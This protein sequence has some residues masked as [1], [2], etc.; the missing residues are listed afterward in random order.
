MAGRKASS[1]LATDPCPAPAS[2]SDPQ[3]PFSSLTPILC[4]P[5]AGQL[6]AQQPQVGKLS[7]RELGH[8]AL[9]LRAASST[10]AR[11]PSL[12]VVYAARRLPRESVALYLCL[13]PAQGNN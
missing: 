10:E 13:G 12:H 11:S 5:L 7:P 3:R 6:S 1:P 8:R 9:A 2:P 4:P